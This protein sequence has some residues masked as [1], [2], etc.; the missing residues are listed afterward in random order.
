MDQDLEK[1]QREIERARRLA[2]SVADRTTSQRLWAFVDELK[3]KLTRRMEA[4]RAKEQIRVR[5]HDLWVQHGHPTGRDVE[6][7]LQA[8]SELRAGSTD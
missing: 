3:Q 2:T 1:L 6:F 7:W 8:E 4:R 5:A